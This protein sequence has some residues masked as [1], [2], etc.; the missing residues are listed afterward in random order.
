MLRLSQLVVY[1]SDFQSSTAAIDGAMLVGNTGDEPQDRVASAVA[2]SR[3]DTGC[4][5]A[6]SQVP[7][8]V[9]NF[10]WALAGNV[11][12]AGCQWL[13]LISIAKLG[14]PEMVGQLALGLAIT[15]PV[16]LFANLQL[17]AVLATDSLFEFSF[18]EY[19]AMRLA[20]SAVALTVITAL[21]LKQQSQLTELVILC[22]GLSKLTD[23]ISDL[24]YGCLQQHE[25][26]DRIAKSMMFKGILSVT[27]VTLIIYSTHN[28]LAGVL[29]L[30]CASASVLICYDIPNCLRVLKNSRESALIEGL[31]LLRPHYATKTF[32]RLLIK[33]APLGVVAMLVSLSG[34]MPRYYIERY[35]GVRQLG[36]FAAM[37]YLVMAESTLAN[38]LAEAVLPRLAKHYASRQM[39]AFR[40]LLSKLLLVA[41]GIGGAGVVVALVGGRVLL[42]LLYRPEY[43]EHVDVFVWLMVA[44]ALGCV[45]T[46]LG[47]AATST[48]AFSHLVFPYLV[49]VGVAAAASRLLIPAFGLLGAAWTLSVVSMAS[50][51]VAIIV[52]LIANAKR[53]AAAPKAS[54]K[55]SL[56]V[57]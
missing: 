53:A 42:T 24:T 36:I 3:M 11:I 4:I 37:A 39:P 27:A 31:K 49:F 13:I 10:S 14:T 28:L 29:M 55:A 21:A 45:G 44:A 5:P 35:L 19:A 26:M 54:T 12:Y 6:N 7:S 40:Q 2:V 46:F 30:T 47:T 18:Q 25:Q 41:S 33:A 51:L 34:N 57:G 20:T 8:L 32:V 16:V 23:A 9:R 50:C 56:Y 15:A 38:A 22:V 52:I 17:R 43:A 48:R 1:V